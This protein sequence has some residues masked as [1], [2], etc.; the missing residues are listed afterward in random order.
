MLTKPIFKDAKNHY[1]SKVFSLRV[2]NPNLKDLSI[3][4]E[5]KF[6]EHNNLITSIMNTKG[7]ILATEDSCVDL[8]QNRI[9]GLWINVKPKYRNNNYRLGELLRLVSIIGM[10]ENK[11]NSIK[12]FSKDKAIYFHSKYKFAADFTIFQERNNALK[13]LAETESPDM[14]NYR[15]E[16]E[17]L[18]QQINETEDASI[19]RKLCKP[20]SALLTEFIQKV[21]SLGREEYKKYPFD[22][23][24]AM[25]LTRKNI[26]ENRDFFNELFKRHG[27]DYSI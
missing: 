22:N 6:A 5:D 25:I 17:K 1:I 4:F 11:I 13:K 19:Q 14:K 27:I 2:N 16:A 20:S 9:N 8:D 26:L 7:D 24:M 23:G 21:L 12:I 10:L 18:L 3:N 15:Y